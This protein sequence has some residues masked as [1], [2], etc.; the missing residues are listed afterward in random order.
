MPLLGCLHLAQPATGT[1]IP[2]LA[3]PGRAM[4]ILD[5]YVKIR[6]DRMSG[7]LPDCYPQPWAL[8]QLI[9]W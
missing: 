3:K 8:A 1:P 7:S 9:S 6:N 2:D 5:A 4:P